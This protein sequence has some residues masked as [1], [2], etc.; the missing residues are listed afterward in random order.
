MLQDAA[1]FAEAVRPLIDKL[2]KEQ[3]RNVLRAE[4][5]DVVTPADGGKMGVRQPFGKQEIFLPYTQEVAN[6]QRDD[7]VL[8]LWRGSLSNGKVWCFGNGPEGTSKNFVTPEMY[9]AK[10][11][12]VSDDTAALQACLVNG[13]NVILSGTYLITGPLNIANR[14]NIFIFGGSIVRPSDQTFNTLVGKGCDN[15]T[16]EN[17]TFDGNGNNREMTYTW[18]DNI[19]ACMILASQSKNISVIGC[20]IYNYN[21]GVFINGADVE[22][23]ESSFQNTAMNGVIQ[24]CV[25]NNCH[26]AVD[27]YGKAILIDHNSFYGNTGKCVQVEPNSTSQG[28]ENPMD[29]PDYYMSAVGAVV[30]NNTF[31]DNADTDVVIH[32]NTYG[33]I[34]EGNTFLNYYRAIQLNTYDESRGVCIFGN[35]LMYQKRQEITSS[36]RPWAYLAAIETVGTGVEIYGNSLYSP[37]VGIYDRGN[38]EIRD[39]VISKPQISGIVVYDNSTVSGMTVIRGNRITGH[40]LAD[41]ANFSCYAVVFG[42][43]VSTYYF[44]DNLVESTTRPVYVFSGT[45]AFVKNLISNQE[46]SAI[47]KPSGIYEYSN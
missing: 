19:Q 22:N 8:V 7:A 12:G 27:T 2:V 6:A 37:V 42:K 45:E 1:S 31:I 3:T 41:G 17:V 36:K 13:N 32:P 26:S 34:I 11:D 9:G 18:K 28:E 33:T 4:R 38:S 46:S 15:I 21:Y 5:F 25:F 40:S 35:V 16:I 47:T 29:E 23:E 43:T 24:N 14:H 44:I 30:S 20:R 39:N 10:G